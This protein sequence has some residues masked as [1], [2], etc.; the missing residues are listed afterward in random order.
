[1]KGTTE[2][3]HSLTDA[4]RDEILAR[5]EADSYAV[6]PFTLPQDMIDRAIAYMDT[7][8]DNG[9]A[10]DPEQRF[11]I[12]TNIVESDPVFRE[13]LMYQA[14]LAVELRRLWPD[15]SS[16]TRY[17]ACETPESGTESWKY[18]LAF[19]RSSRVPGSR[20]AVARCTPC[21]SVTFSRMRCT[22]NQAPWK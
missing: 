9:R 17:V 10:E 6:L 20:R 22:K 21:G 2:A 18:W 13:F 5:I 19:R 7:Y 15:V 1:M 4:Q 3:E 14:R 8:C 11:F 12:E 16:G